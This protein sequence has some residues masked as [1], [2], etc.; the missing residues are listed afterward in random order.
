MCIFEQTG[1]EWLRCTYIFFETMFSYVHKSLPDK[2][3]NA[4]FLQADDT[5]FVFPRKN[6]LT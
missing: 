4:E 5:A 1:Q 3:A 2:T 6:L